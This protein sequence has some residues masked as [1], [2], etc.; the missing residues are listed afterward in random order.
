MAI[1]EKKP[2]ERLSD[3]L[4]RSLP[5]ELEAG[6]SRG[7]ATADIIAKFNEE[8]PRE[9]F[10]PFIWGAANNALAE[11][12][13]ADATAYL[14]AVTTAGGT[15]DATIDAAV[16]TL[17]TS[18]KSNG[19]YSKLDLF[20]PLI[21]GTA[22]STALNGIRTNSAYDITWNGSLTFNTLGVTGTGTNGDYGNTNYNWSTEAASNSVAWGI[23]NTAGNFGQN[24]SEIYSHGGYDGTYLNA[25]VGLI[26]SMELRGWE[27]FEPYGGT[28]IAVPRT[29]D[30]QAVGTFDT[31]TSTKKLYW[32]ADVPGYLSGARVV[33]GGIGLANQEEFLF[34]LNINGNPYTGNYW[35]G[36]LSFFWIGEYLNDTEV[37]TISEIITTFNTSL[38]RNV[39]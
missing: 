25:H 27:V 26:T 21:G 19:L 30:G 9:M 15:T 35:N 16:Q 37:E 39:Y 1:P 8:P 29:S 17:F 11:S 2:Y 34:T 22:A 33:S 20:Y 4:E 13:D 5:A 10:A 23:Y 38:S 14:A 7:K 24:A 12:D 18:L 3:Y 28:T 36:R 6:K 31:S 32:N